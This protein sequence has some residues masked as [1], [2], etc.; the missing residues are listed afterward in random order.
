MVLEHNN[1]YLLVLKF[2]HLNWVLFYEELSILD[3]RSVVVQNIIPIDKPLITDPIVIP[4]VVLT[5]YSLELIKKDK[6]KK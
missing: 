3:H 1:Y 6:N 2:Y 4:E 5:S